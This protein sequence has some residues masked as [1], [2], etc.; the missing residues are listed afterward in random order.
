M[1]WAF[2]KRP[3]RDSEEYWSTILHLQDVVKRT[4]WPFA[5][6]API[7]GKGFDYAIQT[8]Q[9]AWVE[10]VMV[11]SE[12][13]YDKFIFSFIP[14]GKSHDH[15]I[16]IKLNLLLDGLSRSNLQ[17]CLAKKCG[18]YFVNISLRKKRFCSPRC[19][20]RFNAEKRRTADPEGYREYQ[21]K[22]MK[23]RYREKNGHKRLRTKSRKAKKGE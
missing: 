8:G 12:W 4:F 6:K 19:L 9:K 1:V 22:L 16:Q 7:P 18:K 5:E 11:R 3:P 14:L 20:W 13:N 10:T 21:R 15:Y 2:K 17:R 23:D